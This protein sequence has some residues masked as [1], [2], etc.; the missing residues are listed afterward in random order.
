MLRPIIAVLLSSMAM[1]SFIGTPQAHAGESKKDSISLEYKYTPIPAKDNAYD[2]LWKAC[3][4]LSEDSETLSGLLEKKWDP[5]EARAVLKRQSAVLLGWQEAKKRPKL[6]APELRSFSDKV[7]YLVKWRNLA[8]L[9]SIHSRLQAENGKLVHSI[10][11]AKDVLRLG[12]MTERYA[13]SFVGSLIGFKIKQMGCERIQQLLRDHKV[14]SRSCIEMSVFLDGHAPDRAAC[15]D[16]LRNEYRAIRVLV[17]KVHS[18]KTDES[19]RSFLSEEDLPFLNDAHKA[20]EMEKKVA[21]EL[22]EDSFRTHLKNCALRYHDRQLS[23]ARKLGE[24]QPQ[25][26]SKYSGRLFHAAICG[27]YDKA[28]G[29]LDRLDLTIGITKLQLCLAAYSAD[30][31]GEL[32]KSLKELVPKY[33]AELPKDP[34][35][36][37]NEPL[38]Y[39]RGKQILYSIGADSVDDGGTLVPL[40]TR[41]PSKSWKMKDPSFPIVSLKQ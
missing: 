15:Q 17:T 40:T 31:D 39:S 14:G 33:I 11:T 29:R 37:K 4:T 3:E 26:D 24:V 20:P 23:K 41:F 34:Y 38:R 5:K 1:V 6:Q 22:I 2:I 10:L 18:G 25:H 27:L 36:K 9:L 8:R 21:V 7:I 19:V 16:S 28:V 13:S 35:S 12:S 32:P 30:N